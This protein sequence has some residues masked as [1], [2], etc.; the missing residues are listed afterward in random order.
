M[1]RFAGALGNLVIAA[2]AIAIVYGGYLVVRTKALNDD[3]AQYS[4]KAIRAMAD[5]WNSEEFVKRAAPETMGQGG[6]K[7]MPELF[8]WYSALGK[9]K[10]VE[11]PTGRVGTGAYPGTAIIGTWADYSA[12]AEFEAGPAEIGLIL[13]RVGDTWQIA[14]FQIRAEVFSRLRPPPSLQSEQPLIKWK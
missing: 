5:P 1:N 8:A 7:F 2:L 13:K 10:S 11:K 4:E 3:A 6:D 14:N 12:R 9:L